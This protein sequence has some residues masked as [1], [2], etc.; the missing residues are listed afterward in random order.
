MATKKQSLETDP[1]ELPPTQ[2]AIEPETE[3][4]DSS[5]HEIAPEQPAPK[6]RGR[7]PGSGAKKSSDAP[8]KS[9][10]KQAQDS[11]E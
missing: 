1:F 4:A 5:G 10:A 11:V 7:P 3:N 6:R 8:Q 9:K 2:P